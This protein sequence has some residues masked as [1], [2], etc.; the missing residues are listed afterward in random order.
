MLRSTVKEQCRSWGRQAT[1]SSARCGL[2]SH[3]SAATARPGGPGSGHR[4]ARRARLDPSRTP[5]R[6]A[7]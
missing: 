3:P 1:E 4:S 7:L 6:G 2:V 5:D